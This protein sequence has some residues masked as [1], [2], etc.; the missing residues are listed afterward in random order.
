MQLLKM[1]TSAT[2]AYPTSLQRHVMSVMPSQDE[3]DREETRHSS[4]RVA[5]AFRSVKLALPSLASDSSVL[6][7]V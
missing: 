4:C 3:E 1:Q 2:F 6:G 5:Y 7:C